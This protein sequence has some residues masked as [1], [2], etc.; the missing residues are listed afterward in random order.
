[1]TAF[2]LGVR[3]GIGHSTG[4]LVVAIIFILL[5]RTSDSETVDIPQ[6]VSRFFES[7]VGVFMILLGVYGIRRALK[8]RRDKL[9]DSLTV[10]AAEMH[11]HAHFENR[12]ID[13]PDDRLT[14]DVEEMQSD[15]VSNHS[16]AQFENRQI[17][18]SVS[19]SDEASGLVE[20]EGV[21]FTDKYCGWLGRLATRKSLSLVAGIVHGLAG[22]GGVLGVIPAVQLHNGRL[23]ALYLGCFCASSTLTMGM[24]AVFYGTCTAKLGQ[25]L[26]SVFV[27]ELLSASLSILV[28]VTWLALLSVGKLDDVFH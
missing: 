14:L 27:I 26:H 17:S 3:W 13:I 28:G 1:M 18:L 7:L 6:G 5:S 4:L 24:F 16:H 19:D 9:D 2:F 20:L 21:T 12:E 15:G 8:H 25:C 10:D 23:A 22:P 11:S